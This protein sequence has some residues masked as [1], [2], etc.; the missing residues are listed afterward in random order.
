MEDAIYTIVEDLNGNKKE[1]LTE[2]ERAGK[3]GA[4]T[5]TLHYGY[6]G[7]LDDPTSSL[8]E[9]L[10]KMELLNS[11]FMP[12]LFIRGS[13]TEFDSFLDLDISAEVGPNM[14]ARGRILGSGTEIGVTS[15][16][17][18]F[19]LQGSAQLDKIRINPN[20]GIQDPNL[21]FSIGGDATIFSGTASTIFGSE[22]FAPEVKDV[23]FEGGVSIL[24]VKTQATNHTPMGKIELASGAI[25]LG[26][27]TIKASLSTPSFDMT[28]G[29]APKKDFNMQELYQIPAD[30][31]RVGTGN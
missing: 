6:H 10:Y 2:L 18:K 24:K 14:T 31:V 15:E 17:A 4:G 8:E 29:G 27:L 12:T 7:N 16:V 3:G 11:T 5:L 20:T 26:L 13:E 9:T 25:G 28:K 19:G 23:E 1:S 21:K 22:D 30:N